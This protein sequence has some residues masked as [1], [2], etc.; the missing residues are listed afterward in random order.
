MRTFLIAYDLAHPTLNKHAIATQIMGV[1]AQWARPL[2]CMWFVRG[3]IG[4]AEI[5]EALQPYLDEDDGLVVQ[6]VSEEAALTNT[7]LRWFR[8]RRP[9]FDIETN[10]NIVAFP[11]V[12]ACPT[13]QT[14]LPLATAC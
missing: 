11:S 3:D 12:P 10:S 4:E 9:A 1:A 14:E 2:D 13:A 7:T 5:E 8:Q 6:A